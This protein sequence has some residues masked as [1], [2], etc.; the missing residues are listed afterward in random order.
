M[1][2][3]DSIFSVAGDELSIALNFGQDLTGYTV[4]GR[5]SLSTGTV[6]ERTAQFSDITTGVGS[7]VFLPADTVAGKHELELI[8]EQD[9]DGTTTTIPAENPLTVSIRA[10]LE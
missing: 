2:C 10:S 3:I 5:L 7:V 1:A 9:S 6:V 8:I 4:I